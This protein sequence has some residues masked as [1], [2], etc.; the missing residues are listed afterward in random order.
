[1]LILTHTGLQDQIYNQQMSYISLYY[2]I[3]YYLLTFK[4]LW[5]SHYRI[6]DVAVFKKVGIRLHRQHFNVTVIL[7][8]YLT[9]LLSK[10]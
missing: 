2:L 4:S 3:S 9:C 6:Y 1:M 7:E 5:V 8:S 10:S